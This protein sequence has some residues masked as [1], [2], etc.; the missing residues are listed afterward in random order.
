M[1]FKNA[2]L[3]IRWFF[4]MKNTMKEGWQPSEFEDQVVAC[5][6]VER[7]LNE[8]YSTKELKV[9]HALFAGGRAD[10][11]IQI[12]RTYRAP[13]TRRCYKSSK[14]YNLFNELMNRL[15]EDLR[16]FDYIEKFI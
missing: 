10:A 16:R 4:N 12:K 7:I 9:F 2:E 3:C 8:N 6:D 1:E 13:V 14:C 15:E 11:V 5:I